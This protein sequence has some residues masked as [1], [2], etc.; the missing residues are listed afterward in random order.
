MSAH[1]N[2]VRGLLAGL[3]IAIALALSGWALATTVHH[4][5]RITRTE[6]SVDGIK[7]WLRRVEEKLDRALERRYTP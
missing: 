6:T 5:E 1:A 3:L 7:A 2:G 4:G